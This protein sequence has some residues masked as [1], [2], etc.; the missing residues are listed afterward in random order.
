MNAQLAILIATLSCQDP[1]LGF[2]DFYAQFYSHR[3]PG[4]YGEN[5]TE[6][7]R[8]ESDAAADFLDY[9]VARMEKCR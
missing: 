8:R 6:V 7:F 3:W 5:F 4:A 9:R 2:R 1:A